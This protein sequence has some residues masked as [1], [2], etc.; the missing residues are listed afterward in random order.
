LTIYPP[1]AFC[2]YNL[3]SIV[4]G[5]VYFDQFALISPLHLGLVAVGIIVLLVGVWVVSIQAGGGGVDIDR[6]KEGG[7]SL[8]DDEDT[9]SVGSDT[10]PRDFEEGPQTIGQSLLVQGREQQPFRMERHTVSESQTHSPRQ[11][12]LQ[13]GRRVVDD[14]S[15]DMSP[16]SATVRQ[17]MTSDVLLSP[18]STRTRRRRRSTIQPS[19][20]QPM[21]P[22][23]GGS[24]VLGSGLSIGLGPMSPG[25]SIVP[26]DRRRRTSGIGFAD[27]VE[28]ALGQRRRRTVSEGDMRRL[29]EGGG[30]EEVVENRQENSSEPSV[31]ESGIKANMRWEWARRMFLDRR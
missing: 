10:E 17:G 24:S 9:L 22:P 25:F 20:T 7:E 30:D 21:S 15:P 31:V 1:A 4:N 14:T 6:W 3:S 11:Q 19:D 23:L 2:F 28:D 16:R 27:V 12:S 26:R 18:S 8:S 29:A 5:L 13:V